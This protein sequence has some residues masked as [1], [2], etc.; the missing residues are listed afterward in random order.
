[1][2]DRALD[3]DRPLDPGVAALLRDCR[4]LIS[5]ATR[6][7]EVQATPGP[8]WRKRAADLMKTIDNLTRGHQ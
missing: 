7:A 8:A 3:A 5:L 4:D 2:A 1:M 6:A